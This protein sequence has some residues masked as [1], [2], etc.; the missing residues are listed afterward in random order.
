MARAFNFSLQKVLDV[1]RHKEDQRAIE[2]GKAKSSLLHE[3]QKLQQLNES[4]ES[5]L[6]DN[7]QAETVHPDLNTIKISG[8]YLLQLGDAIGNQKDEVHKKG[9]VV[10]SRRDEL[11]GAVKDKK[12]VE[13]LKERKFDEHKKEVLKAE[14]KK[15][16]EVAV[17]MV[18]QNKRK[19]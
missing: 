8:S 5:L 16:D 13:K 7:N 11:L 12:I 9:K 14:H 17:R 18:N 4:K 3:Q 6:N 10:I 19:D 1:R 2:L 15:D